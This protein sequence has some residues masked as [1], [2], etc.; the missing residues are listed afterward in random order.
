LY[1]CMRVCV[2]ARVLKHQHTQEEE[3]FADHVFVSDPA[4]TNRGGYLR[5]SSSD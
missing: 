5:V 2:C 4:R 1:A 3:V